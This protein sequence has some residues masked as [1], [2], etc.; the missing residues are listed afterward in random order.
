MLKSLI[1]KE[2]YE[3]IYRLWDTVSPVPFDCG[4]FCGAL[5]CVDPGH[6][7]DEMG[8]Y[9]LPGEDKV[10]DKKDP[11]L[12]W[13]AEEAQEYDFPPS[14]QGKVYFAMCKG[15][16]GCKRE[17]RPIQCRTFPILPHLTENGEL[18]LIYNDMDLPYI[19]PMIEEKSALN[20]SFLR[21]TYRNWQKLL[22]DPLILD[23]VKNDSKQREKV[24]IL[25][26]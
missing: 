1:T 19:C 9:L 5:C 4:L 10:H 24:E 21:V 11:W 26:P 13:S 15:P 23:L 7:D 18:V 2:E 8:L 3:E 14:W 22:T 25:Y 12:S 16:S 6:E 17:K 20:E